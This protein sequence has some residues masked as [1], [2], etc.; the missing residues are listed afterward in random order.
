M[1]LETADVV[2]MGDDLERPAYALHL[3]RRT[4]SVVRQNLALSTA[5]IGAL[6]VGAIGGL[7]YL[8]VAV[9]GHEVSEL[10]VIASGPRMLRA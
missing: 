9:L 3:A 8:P 6:V 1:A 2:L 5:V 10:A 4:Q 7:F